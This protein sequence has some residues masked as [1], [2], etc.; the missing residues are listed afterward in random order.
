MWHLALETIGLA[1]SVALFKH[2]ELV[3][4]A[5]LPPEIG[6]ARSLLPAIDQLC[7]EHQVSPAD[8]KLISLSF[9][10]GSFTG[11]RVSVATAKT[12]AFALKIPV[13]AVDTL[14]VLAYAATREALK[15]YAPPFSMAVAIDAY[16]KQVFRL[17]AQ[18]D[19]A[20]EVSAEQV[21]NSQ[22]AYPF[23]QAV[24][25]IT[26]ASHC[27]DATHWQQSPLMP[28]EELMQASMELGDTT[29]LGG[30]REDFLRQPTPYVLA[31]N[32]LLRYPL[33]IVDEMVLASY[34]YDVNAVDVGQYAYYKFQQGHTTDALALLPNYLRSSAAEEKIR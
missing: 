4:Q 19:V 15:K 24:L 22:V 23:E 9:G 18:V 1:G 3:C 28:L 26:H 16:R 10:P 6:S 30:I 31:G 21:K 11:L 7:R 14:E 17:L 20:T 34:R 13:T 33:S 12:L 5:V 27:C 32:A 2:G 29:L 8:L 25:Q